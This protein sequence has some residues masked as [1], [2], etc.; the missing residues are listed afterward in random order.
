MGEIWGMVWPMPCIF[1]F[2]DF[3]MT[4]ELAMVILAGVL[5]VVA[6][7]RLARA[8]LNYRGQRLITCP[9]NQKPAGVQVDAR[10]AA[11]T[12]LGHAPRLRLNQCSRWPE[13][14]GCGQECLRQIEAAPEDCLVRNILMKWYEGKSCVSCGRPIGE[15]VVG[16]VKPAL[17]SAG[18]NTVEW[19]DIPAEQLSEVLSA[20]QPVC[21]ACHMANKMVRDHPELVTD[22]SKGF[23]SPG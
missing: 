9:E 13:K 4:V 10:H 21:F 1:G 22:R 3:D 14:A 6:L 8:W 17:L 19:S 12:A 23:S 7:W 15:I 5:V 18:N 2:S 16:G 20:A 11:A